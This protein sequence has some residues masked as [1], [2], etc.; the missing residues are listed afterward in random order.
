M[1]RIDIGFEIL[2]EVYNLAILSIKHNCLLIPNSHTKYNQATNVF[3]EDPAKKYVTK[4]SQKT[5]LHTPVEDDFFI[6]K[7]NYSTFLMSSGISFKTLF[8]KCFKLNESDFEIKISK[9]N[10][11]KI[12]NFNQNCDCFLEKNKELIEKKLEKMNKKFKKDSILAK[13]ER[14]EIKNETKNILLDDVKKS[15][16]SVQKENFIL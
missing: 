14:K 11:I 7:N 5:L 10:E 13:K 8:A 15:S 4:Y 16:I 9:N 6:K 12:E 3:F 2:Q 1:K